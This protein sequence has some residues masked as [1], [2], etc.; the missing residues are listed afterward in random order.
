MTIALYVTIKAVLSVKR[1][2]SP[3]KATVWLTLAPTA[4]NLQFNKHELPMNT[5][6]VPVNHALFTSA[7]LQT[8]LA[9]LTAPWTETSTV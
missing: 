2:T 3:I 6:T 1:S 9:T 8:A 5:L 7:W 4:K